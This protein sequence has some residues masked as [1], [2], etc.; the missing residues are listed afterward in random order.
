MYVCNV[1]SNLYICNSYIYI[2]I[3]MCVCACVYE[4]VYFC[5]FVA[6]FILKY[7]K[8]DVNMNI[9][10][11]MNIRIYI[12]FYIQISKKQRMCIYIYTH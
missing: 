6:W 12:Q 1:V 11:T 7:P 8:I 9:S 3:Q 2:Y 4:F 5:S 10:K